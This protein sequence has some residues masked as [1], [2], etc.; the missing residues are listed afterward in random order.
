MDA[1]ET[2]AI[3]ISHWRIVNWS[4]VPKETALV[5]V[6]AS[7]GD[8]FLDP[9]FESHVEGALEAGKIVGAYH[10]YR[11]AKNGRK[12]DPAAQAEFFLEQTQ[13]YQG[14]ILLQAVDWERSH[15]LSNGSWYNPALGSEPEDLYRFFSRL[16]QAPWKSF[17]LLYTNLATWQAW[18]LENWRNGWNGPGWLCSEG[19]VDGLWVAAW[20]VETPGRLP[21]PF[22]EYWMHQF[23]ANY[24]MPG[25]Y[26]EE[27]KPSG[28]D[29][30][31]IPHS[32]DEIKTTLAPGNPRAETPDFNPEEILSIYRRG[33]QERTDSLIEYLQ[34]ERERGGT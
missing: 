25:I 8:D 27:G 20:G 12:V 34:Q 5:M 32:L 9:R 18:K 31:R 14:D 24:S 11:T 19:L 29:A 23:S 28:V 17:T 26:T 33:W 4:E 22:T 13:A 21:R 1:N 2:L 10:F 3:D 30:N 7:E 6:K 15:K 16:G